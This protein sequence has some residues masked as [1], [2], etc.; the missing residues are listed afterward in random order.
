MRLPSG[1]VDQYVYFYAVDSTDFTTPETGL[2]GFTVYRSRDGAAPAAYTTPTVNETDVTN[3]PGVYELL[4]D[5]DTTIASG[6][7][8]EEM[9]LHI[10]KTGMAPV[11]RT[12]ELYRPKITLGETLTVS[13]GAVGSIA[14]GG[15]TAASIATDAIDAD[16]LATNA[17]DEIQTTIVV[18]LDTILTSM[19][20][21]TDVGLVAADVTSILAD[22][23]ELQTD[24]ANG[25]RLDLILDA[26]ASQ[27][28][29]DDIPTNAE[30]ATALGT[31]DDATLAAI[32]ALSIPTAIQNADALLNRDFASVSDT[33]ARSP[34]NALRL[35]RNKYSIAAGMLT[36]TK[37]ND[38]TPA[39]TAVITS[40]ASADPIIGSDPA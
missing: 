20:T 29:V 28:S 26:R 35:L 22:T 10:S 27:T 3:M 30:L 25:G 34:L 7:D 32:A 18:Y 5:E 2:T 17:V 39:W 37:E 40:D 4:V 1:T 19:A 9:V 23:N 21:N 12:I 14:T 11:V 13:S 16:A 38:S 8:S 24:W 6:N 36:V 33:N 15:I 31:A